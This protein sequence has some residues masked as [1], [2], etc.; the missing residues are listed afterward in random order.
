MQMRKIVIFLLVSVFV[1][2][3]FIGCGDD[4]INDRTDE[5]DKN[6]INDTIGSGT[7]SKPKGNGIDNKPRRI[8]NNNSNNLIIYDYE[9]F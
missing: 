9:K 1:A 2:A 3:I 4:A 5:F 8:R 6:T 7:I